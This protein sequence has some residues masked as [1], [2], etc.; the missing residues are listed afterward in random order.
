MFLSSHG[1]AAEN[2]QFGVMDVT[3]DGDVI[4]VT[5][6]GRRGAIAVPGMRIQIQC[7]APQSTT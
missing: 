4:T 1:E 6:Q 2:G 7:R 5:I 3:D